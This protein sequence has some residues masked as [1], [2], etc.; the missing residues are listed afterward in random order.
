MQFVAM[1]CRS[2]CKMVTI[3]MEIYSS[4]HDLNTNGARRRGRSSGKLIAGEHL[5]S[6]AVSDVDLALAE[7]ARSGHAAKARGLASADLGDGRVQGVGDV[8]EVGNARLL[9][10]LEIRGTEECRS[11]V[12]CVDAESHGGGDEGRDGELHCGLVTGIGVGRSESVRMDVMSDSRAKTG[13]KTVSLLDHFI[14]KLRS[15]QKHDL[16]L[17]MKIPCYS[18]SSRVLGLN[19]LTYVTLV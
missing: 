15:I 13:T 19:G 1:N 4:G 17:G 8:S 11:D 7:E 10:A 6:I 2:F 12:R 9:P 3:S 16:D 5:A 18:P 14:L